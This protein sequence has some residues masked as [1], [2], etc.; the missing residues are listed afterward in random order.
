MRCHCGFEDYEHGLDLETEDG[1]KPCAEFGKKRKRGGNFLPAD[2]KDL[3][4]KL[5]LSGKSSRQ[6]MEDTG[7][8][9]RVI[10]AIR[11]TLT[12]PECPCGKPGGHR[13]WCSHRYAN[14]PER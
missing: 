5:L 14:S 11:R 2:R 4:V 13:G 8:S 3:I 6:I 7:H 1:R 12:V 9:N 10:T